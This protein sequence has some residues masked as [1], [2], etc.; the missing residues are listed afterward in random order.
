[1]PNKHCLISLARRSKWQWLGMV[2]AIGLFLNGAGQSLSHAQ[3]PEQ[4]SASEPNLTTLQAIQWQQLSA[5]YRALALQTYAAASAAVRRQVADGLAIGP[6]AE[7]HCLPGRPRPAVILD[8][9]ETVIDNQKYQ[10]YLLKTGERFSRHSWEKWV[11]DG[12]GQAPLIPGAKEFIATA[13]ATGVRVVYISNR[14]EK[15]MQ[16]RATIET[17]RRHG[18]NVTG[19]ADRADRRLLLKDAGSDKS[20]RRHLVTEQYCVIALI[21]DALGDFHETFDPTPQTT[22]TTRKQAVDLMRSNWGRR[23]FVLPNPTYGAWQRM[24]DRNDPLSE[25]DDW[26][27]VP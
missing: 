13:E 11:H 18:I 1:M 26:K 24:L 2:V 6:H 3:T 15:P 5:E 14:P 8:L 10:G 7:Q 20:K 12:A 22:V 23:W 21:G 9:D 19:L 27:P 17:L 4:R 25:I 16:R